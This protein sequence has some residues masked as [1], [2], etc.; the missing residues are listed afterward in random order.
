MINHQN[1]LDSLLNC[2]SYTKN[3]M[4]F[5]IFGGQVI[6]VNQRLLGISITRKK[7][8][9]AE[10]FCNTEVIQRNN[11]P[12]FKCSSISLS[13]NQVTRKLDIVI[14]TMLITLYLLNSHQEGLLVW[15]NWWTSYWALCPNKYCNFSCTETLSGKDI[16]HPFYDDQCGLGQACGICNNE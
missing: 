10:Y 2:C 7:I 13:C 3:C 6:L 9:H 15:S 16:L 4:D 8:K 14:A 11:W 5:D 12:E 1:H